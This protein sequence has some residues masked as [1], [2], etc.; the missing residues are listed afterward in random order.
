MQSQINNLEIDIY[1]F[2]TK[3]E[4]INFPIY[5]NNLFVKTGSL[6]FFE[7]TQKI[8]KEIVTLLPEDSI[9]RLKEK[10]YLATDI[11]PCEQCLFTKNGFLGHEVYMTET[12]F[13]IPPSL[14]MI[15]Q[16]HEE[17]VESIG[18]IPIYRNLILERDLIKIINLEHITVE[19]LS[20]HKIWCLSLQNAIKTIDE[21]DIKTI[22]WSIVQFFPYFSIDSFYDYLKN[23]KNAYPMLF[24]DRYVLYEQI[25][26][27]QE[28]YE[29]IYNMKTDDLKRFNIG[30]LSGQNDL[31]TEL[32]FGITELTVLVQTRGIPD[33]RNIF[34]IIHT[35]P[36]IP[37]I[38]L[39]EYTTAISKVYRK[40][41]SNMDTRL[42]RSQKNCIFFITSLT[43]FREE[44]QEI[45]PGQSVIFELT[46]TGDIIAN[47]K[48]TNTDYKSAH[49]LIT[50]KTQI[51]NELLD[52]LEITLFST[53]N[54][55]KKIYKI[56]KMSANLIWHKTVTDE[57]LKEYFLLLNQH[58][59]LK[60]DTKYHFTKS[61]PS[62]TTEHWNQFRY[63][64]ENYER[65]Y[66]NSI[67]ILNK[68]N[69]LIFQIANITER[70]FKNL[71]KY[72]IY[73]LQQIKISEVFTSKKS[74]K[75]LRAYDPLSYS[76]KGN[77]IY[78]R[79]CQKPKQPVAY[80]T[81]KE[82]IFAESAKKKYNPDSLLEFW[83]FT[84][85]EPLYFYCPNVKYPVPGFITGQHP[86]GYC[87]VCC[88]KNKPEGKYF[89]IHKTCKELHTYK[90]TKYT[91]SSHY[92]INYG[93][94]LEKG[95]LGFL[96]TPINKFITYN[97]DDITIV[98]ETRTMNLFRYN[99]KLYSIDRLLKY[100]KNTIIRDV[101]LTLLQRFLDIPVWRRKRRGAELIKPRAVLEQPDLPAHKKH[102]KKI[103][104]SDLNNPIIIL[105]EDGVFVVVDGFHR[106][107]AAFFQKKQ[108]IK[109]RFVT[110]KQLARCF[111]GKY[112]LD[113][114]TFIPSA[115]TVPREGG[116][117][118]KDPFYY[119]VGVDYQYK[120]ETCSF[121]QSVCAILDRAV[122]EFIDEIIHNLYLTEMVGSYEAKYLAEI[123]TSV[124][125]EDNVIETDWEEIFYE[126]LPILYD[127]VPIVLEYSANNVLLHMQH[128]Y[129]RYDDNNYFLFIKNAYYNPVA[130]AIPYIYARR[131]AF[132]K[133][134]FTY[135]DHIIRIFE[136]L[137]EKKKQE[138]AFT[139][140][141]V[142]T[143]N[144]KI[145]QVLGFSGQAYAII[146]EKNGK[147][148]YV[149]IEKTK[150]TKLINS[151]DYT[152]E[153]FQTFN[154]EFKSAMMFI[155][156]YCLQHNLTV[157]IEKIFCLNNKVVA[158]EIHNFVNF[159]NAN[160]NDFAEFN[161]VIEH[162]NY[163]P[164]TIIN[165]KPE[166][167]DPLYNDYIELSNHRND[168][169]LF[170]QNT[171][172]KHPELLELSTDAAE[173][174]ADKKYKIY[175]PE[176]MQ[177][178][179]EEIGNPL[180]KQLF[181]QG[182][183]NFTNLYLNKSTEENIFVK[184]K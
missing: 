140:N 99:G 29:N 30:I 126:I 46:K 96:P 43:N 75:L 120:N 158:Y 72:V 90:G 146:L 121:L 136:K 64:T 20:E 34:N 73:S 11:L 62:E 44:T 31:K 135:D 144:Y 59:L 119:A 1:N 109:V 48:F 23:N 66:K 93:K 58:N 81:E 112:K 57:N 177:A 170:K 39:N 183:Y 114:I 117:P 35:T 8:T 128:N 106:L 76:K 123:I 182:F 80:L 168:Y 70:D 165:A 110:P 169:V 55:Q 154:Y 53:H 25:M 19:E 147:F 89:E 163:A 91:S 77:Q 107:S 2:E 26:R 42:F 36:D 83:N 161:P 74:L 85:E 13:N 16:H 98:S 134:I 68:Y 37:I 52:K 101:P 156:E 184:T 14:Q 150:I 49:D 153:K 10:I 113:E 138:S 97:M 84:R 130:V 131:N 179:L 33:L 127:F 12:V 24:L 159:V 82:A 60:F 63:Y 100:T 67:A 152:V 47:A 6:E 108:T 181:K 54:E 51:L 173:K 69:E 178:L 180:K 40:H 133:T 95:R 7:D 162:W 118:E 18:N 56:Q 103:L 148:I 166:Y 157:N 115:V 88:R 92:I 129:N 86:E 105:N 132:E 145:H 94:I 21:N 17:P 155:R 71:F 65:I 149:A 61:V 164:E 176:F 143:T 15:L 122:P 141:K 9:A 22:Y 137:I 111:L 124:F 174:F 87:Q 27:E 4:T 32:S 41:E 175:D 116:S 28:I 139:Y 102:Y 45:D 167:E 160:I 5:D 3:L 38:I 104:S 142:I 79:L 78:A 50:K 171:L 172:T 125:K 151:V